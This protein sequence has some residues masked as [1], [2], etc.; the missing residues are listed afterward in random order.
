MRLQ[1]AD[2]TLTETEI[3]SV[4]ERIVYGA[5][6]IIT[7]KSGKDP[8]EVFSSAMGNVKPMV[9]V[10]SRRVGGAT[11]QV[12]TPVGSRRQRALAIRWILEACRGR[13][14]R[15]IANSLADEFMAAYKREGAAMTKRENVH[16]MADANKAFAHF[17]W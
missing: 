9:E 17:A 6:D 13:K 2:R 15:G 10:K 8:L 1:A 14:G 7:T 5:F 12:P 11:Y 3:D 16:K 4:A